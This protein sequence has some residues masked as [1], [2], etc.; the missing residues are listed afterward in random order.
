MTL[1]WVLE[2]C[3]RVAPATRCF[4][5]L[6]YLFGLSFCF[7]MWI[8]YETRVKLSQLFKLD[9]SAL[10]PKTILSQILSALIADKLLGLA[11]LFL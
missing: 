3:Q 2:L 1:I 8:I 10:V 11:S 4:N 7:I 9:E 5:N 6:E